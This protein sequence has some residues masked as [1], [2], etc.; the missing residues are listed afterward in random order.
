VIALP[1][2]VILKEFQRL[3]DLAANDTH[4][5]SPP[6]PSEYLRMTPC[7]AAFPGCNGRLKA[8]TTIT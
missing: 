7:G 6:D 2:S 4:R 8:C 5:R 1:Y 3:K